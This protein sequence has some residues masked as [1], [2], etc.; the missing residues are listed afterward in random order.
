MQSKRYESRDFVSEMF[1]RQ[2]RRV[3]SCTLTSTSSERQTWKTWS[4]KQNLQGSEA[5]NG[6]EEVTQSGF[7]SS[8][9]QI[10]FSL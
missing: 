4:A 7:V 2:Q 8:E 5:A 9:K 10:D 6:R 3:W 1:I